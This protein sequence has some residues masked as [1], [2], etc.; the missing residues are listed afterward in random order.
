VWNK[1]AEKSKIVAFKHMGLDG[2]SLTS[3]E[4]FFFQAGEAK[5]NKYT[6]GH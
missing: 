5:S 1:G 6:F 4:A 3:R 2:Q